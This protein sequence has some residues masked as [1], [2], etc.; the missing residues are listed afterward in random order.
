M[1]PILIGLFYS[2]VTSYATCFN[3]FNANIEKALEVTK[4]ELL[5]WISDYLHDRKLGV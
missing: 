3:N 1:I 5:N 2:L 4:Y